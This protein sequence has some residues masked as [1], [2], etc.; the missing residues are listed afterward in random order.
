MQ[1]NPISRGKSSFQIQPE[2]METQLTGNP[3]TLVKPNHGRFWDA[4]KFQAGKYQIIAVARQTARSFVCRQI[5]WQQYFHQW[6]CFSL[7]TVSYYE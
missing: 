2:H 5:Q 4:E 1:E 6:F 7:N 3:T